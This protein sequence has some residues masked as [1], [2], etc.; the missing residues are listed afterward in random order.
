MNIRKYFTTSYVLRYLVIIFSLFMIGLGMSVMRISCLGTEPF[1]CLNFSIS[2]H[3]AVPMGA[4]MA[5]I[6]AVLLILS[7]FTMRET[8]G[9]GTVANM[10][11]LGTA[12]DFWGNVIR[13][14]VGEI[15]F[16]GMDNIALRMLLLCAGMV[17][18]VI[19]CSFYMSSEMGMAPYDALG[20]IVEKMTG[21]I[22]FKWAR[23]AIDSFCVVIA[24]FIAQLEG[25]QWE[26]I[27]IG[28]VIMALCIGPLLSFFRK[29]AA[30]PFIKKIKSL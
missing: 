14:I 5:A 26:L 11:F 24:Y 18:M 7:F 16:S 13:N 22:P 3:F 12:S 6:N 20:Y 28:T 23:V 10:L 30:E 1:S 2:E 8:L 29:A 27:G 25:T 9:F 21:R 4:T 19:S 17:T 15:S